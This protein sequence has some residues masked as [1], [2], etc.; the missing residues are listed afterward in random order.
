MIT[1]NSLNKVGS[2][3]DF[4]ETILSLA[5]DTFEGESSNSK[6]II[7][8]AYY[9]LGWFL[10]D[11][12]KHYRNVPKR[13]MDIDL[14]LTQRHPDNLPLGEYVADG[15]RSLGIRSHRT[16]DR[17][18]RTGLGFGAYCWL[19]ERHPIFSWFHLECLGL[20][21][22]E[23]TSYDPVSME[24]VMSARTKH[25]LWFLTGIAD[26]DGHVHF[27]DKTVDITTFPNTRFVKSIVDS[28][29]IRSSIRFTKGYGVVMVQG[30][31][32]AK[33]GIFNPGS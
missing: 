4:T 30:K 9:F 16:S 17:P 8:S 14:Q 23:R 5:N 19:F 12:G 24:W 10:G 32:A 7:C 31:D 2:H 29:Q 25:R 3:R 33:V 22:E 21:W 11:L 18:P 27:R 13:A 26:S 28:L 20:K 1:S 15:G 6:R